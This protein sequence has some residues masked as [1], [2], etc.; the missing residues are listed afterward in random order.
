L[1]PDYVK[2]RDM[3]ADFDVR[4]VRM[5]KF[6][7]CKTMGT[8]NAKGILLSIYVSPTAAISTFTQMANVRRCEIKAVFPISEAVPDVQR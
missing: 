6:V 1:N 3:L 8:L 5:P 7:D 2:M 4:G